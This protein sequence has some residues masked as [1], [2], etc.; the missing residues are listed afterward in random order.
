MAMTTYKRETEHGTEYSDGETWFDERHV[1]HH[2][3]DERE[4]A[5][6]P[7]RWAEEQYSFGCYAGRYCSTCWPKSGYRDAYDPDAEFSELDAGER[8]EADY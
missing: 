7:F 4:A 5:G 3:Q 6:K 2:C 8:I 1:C